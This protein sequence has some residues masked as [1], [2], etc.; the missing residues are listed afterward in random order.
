MLDTDQTFSQWKD[1][2]WDQEGP[3]KTLHDINPVRLEFIESIVPLAGKRVLD[4]GCGGGILS[5]AMAKQGA[6]VTGLDISSVLI[7]V[8]E[9][10]ALSQGV[11]IEYTA[12]PVEKYQAESFD[13]I[14]CME[15][16]EHV[17]DP[18][19]IFQEIR[20]LSRE[21][22][23]LILSTIHRT[24]RSYLEMVVGAEYILQLLP[25]QTHDFKK[26]I[27]PGD[28]CAYARAVQYQPIK[29][30]GLRY[31]PWSRKARLSDNVSTNY[32]LACVAE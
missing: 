21:G 23:V 13:V 19:L 11:S 17:S 22:T 16:L 26:F 29:L 9:A 24:L 30:V 18:A 3:L 27:T 15:M 7:Q 1:R 2:W 31:S 32:C 20:R 28:L 8:A 5:E 6:S 4:L 25:R 12:M 14:V 10:H